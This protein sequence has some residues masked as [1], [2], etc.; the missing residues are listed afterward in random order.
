MNG[1]HCHQLSQQLWSIFDLSTVQTQPEDGFKPQE[2]PPASPHIS[3]L[4]KKKL[5]PPSAVAGNKLPVV[6]ST[7]EMFEKDHMEM[8]AYREWRKAFDD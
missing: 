7:F 3:L 5:R 8:T 2:E 1:Q 6:K 4:K